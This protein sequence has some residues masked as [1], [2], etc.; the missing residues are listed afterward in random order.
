MRGFS[1]TIGL[2]VSGTVS[3]FGDKVIVFELGRGALYG[4]TGGLQSQHPLQTGVSVNESRMRRF[5]QR[6]R[7]KN[8]LV[9]AIETFVS[10]FLWSR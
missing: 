6:A 3:A 9:C 8:M 4:S 7:S 5:C 1:Y 2:D 10:R